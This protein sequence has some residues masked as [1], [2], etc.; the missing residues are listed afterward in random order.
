MRTLI[1]GGGTGGHVNPALA[2]AKV[3][4]EQDPKGEILYVGTKH[5]LEADLVPRTGLVFATIDVSG[6]LRKSPAERVS[7]ACKAAG[8][9]LQAWLIIRRFKPD[10]VVGTGGYVCGPVVLAGS[11]AGLPTLIQEQNVFP[12]LTNRMLARFVSRIAVPFEEARRHFATP[13][14]VVVTGNP[15]RTEIMDKKRPEAIAE[16]GLDP[17]RRTLLVFGGSRGAETLNRAMVEALPGLL[18]RR[19]LQVVWATGTAHHEATLKE[20]RQRGVD[21]GRLEGLVL[22]AYLYQQDAALACADLALTRAGGITLAELTALGIPAILVPSPNVTHNHQ[23]FNARALAS[24]G[25]ATI[26]ADSELTGEVLS[27]QVG[28]ILDDPGRLG[29]MAGASRQMGRP[30]AAAEIGREIRSLVLNRRRR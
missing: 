4:A 28:A 5:G 29:E 20:L 13:G 26:I 24:R 1:A 9:V 7:G 17:G 3:L 15:I 25:A 12:G 11:L 18:A 6:L 21:P 19:D 30:S 22:V 27:R 2:I 10:V 8:A 16:M 14:K 23:E